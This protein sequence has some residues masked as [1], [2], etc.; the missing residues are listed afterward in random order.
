MLSCWVTFHIIGH[1]PAVP[2][3]EVNQYSPFRPS[4]SLLQEMTSHTE[5]EPTP[6]D[7]NPLHLRSK[8]SGVI[9]E[10]VCVCVCWIDV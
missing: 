10:S 1:P 2:P 9:G 8:V 7:N 3:F 5:N 6:S 4:K